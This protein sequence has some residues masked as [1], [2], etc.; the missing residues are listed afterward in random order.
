MENNV[1]TGA[2]CF[3]QSGSFAVPGPVWPE[4][5]GIKVAMAVGAA[6]LRAFGECSMVRPRFRTL[7]NPIGI[8]LPTTHLLHMS[9]SEP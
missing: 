6:G 2:P 8:N 9:A 4:Q 5:V 1:T 3:P 7:I